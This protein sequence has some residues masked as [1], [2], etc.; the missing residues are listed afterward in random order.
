MR[1]AA[2]AQRRGGGACGARTPHY[3]LALAEA[4]EPA[5]TGPEQAAW[6]ARLEEEH[7]NLRAALGW[8]LASGDAETALR[9]AA[10]LWRFWEVHGHLSEGRRWLAAALRTGGTGAMRALRARALRGA[11]LLATWQ[12]DYAAARALHAESLAL[13][14]ALADRDGV[15]H[16][17]ENLG[18]VAHEQGDLRRGGGAARGEPR[19]PARAR[20]LGGMSRA[21]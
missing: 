2:G 13:C 20:G 17:L 21:P 10:A 9:L 7:D 6:L 3:F 5:L 8:A 11:G 15:G 16:A 14:R 19:D 4:A 1:G 12:G 18:I